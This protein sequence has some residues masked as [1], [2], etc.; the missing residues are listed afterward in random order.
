M[1]D[2]KRWMSLLS[3][4]KGWDCTPQV[5]SHIYDCIV[6]LTGSK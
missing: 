5:K 4:G 6:F 1:L 3:A 2:C